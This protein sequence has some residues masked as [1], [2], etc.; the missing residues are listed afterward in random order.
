MLT[1][2]QINSITSQQFV[3]ILGEIFEH[4][5]WI[6]EK[7]AQT[8]PYTTLNDLYTEMVST[9][10]VSSTEEKLTL[11]KAHPN[12]GERIEMSHDSILEQS[13]AGLKDLSTEEYT[14][15]IT[16]NQKYTDKFGFPFIL[17]VRGKNKQQIYQAM[18]A[19]IN[20]LKEIEFQ[21]ALQEIY[22]IALLRLKEKILD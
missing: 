17:A 10:E 15:F 11:I 19:R 4:S 20:N 14:Q 8:R 5:P 7:T 21:T 16:M 13:S 3:D 2:E 18:E 9:V 22:K 6:A 1:I 12:L